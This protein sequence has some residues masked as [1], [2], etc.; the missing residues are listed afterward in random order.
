[1]RK[2]DKKI[3]EIDK[4]ICKNIEKSAEDRGNLSQNIL[5]QLRNF[6]EHIMI[7]YYCESNGIDISGVS[8]DKYN[9]IKQAI[10]YSHKNE[11]MNMLIN[12]HNLLQE[13]VSHYTL[14]EE[15]SERL[16]LKYYE[17]LLKTKNML[18]RDFGLE[19]LHN[20]ERFPINLDDRQLKEYYEKITDKLKKNYDTKISGDRYYIN[21]KKPLFINNEIYYEITFS[22]ANDKASKF[23]RNI[24]FTKQDILTNYAVKLAIT[25]ETINMYGKDIPVLIIND[26]EVSIRPCELNNFA[27]ILGFNTGTQANHIE[28]KKLMDFIKKSGL[29]VLNILLL[30][31]KDY[32]EIR[33]RIISSSKKINIFDALDKC[34]NIIIN[35]Y[36][37]S[38]VLRYFIYNLNNKIIKLQRD[39]FGRKCEKLSDLKLKYGCIP[40]DEM[41]FASSL[42]HHNPK[43]YDL[44]SCIEIEDR[45]YELLARKIKN[46]SQ[47][48]GTLY[49]H[50]R[51]LKFLGDIN[52]LKEQYNSRLFYKHK[53]MRD[54]ENIGDNYY[55]YGY[56]E[57]VIN[58]LKQLKEKSKIGLKNYRNRID[59]WLDHGTYVID[60]YDKREILKKMF[61][62]SEVALVYG[63]AGTG[64][65]TMINH[66]SNFF[67]TQKKIFIA[68]TNPAVDNLKRRV[69]APNSEFMTIA[70]FLYSAKDDEYDLLVIDECSTVSN[71]DMNKILEK[72][73]FRLL[74]LVGDTYQ[75]K[76]ITFGNWFKIAK[77]YIPQKCVFE[78]TEPYR[79]K[80]RSLLNLWDRVRKNSNDIIEYLADNDYSG[81]LN[82]SIFSSEYLDEIILCLNYD[83]LYGINNVNRFFQSNNLNESVKWGVATYK[84]NDPVLFNETTRFSPVLFNNLKGKIIRI[85]KSEGEITFDVEV[86]R[87]ISENDITNIDLDLISSKRNSSIVRFSVYRYQNMS[88]ND[89]DSN[90]T[91]VPFQIAYAISIHKAQ[92]LE[93]DSVKVIITDEVGEL[94]THNILY[95]AITRAKSN[96]KIYWSPETEKKVIEGLKIDEGK[97]DN[98]I[99]KGK[100]R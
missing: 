43:I 33:E 70:K 81:S 84:V 52:A 9:E 89:N 21:K 95:T 58:I 74:L 12:F 72:A 79:T 39:K 36:P 8:E 18:S 15:N 91:I 24:A 54:I 3:L 41:P 57:K 88:D 1:M 23:D 7:K 46:N 45:R 67:K 14:N 10:S 50:K 38:N 30:E 94:I 51:E 53:P 65:S 5:A 73:N 35:N 4:N 83:G 32:T 13:S 6:V 11:E 62:G 49:T 86:D 77:S 26:W 71:Q 25:Q 69:L 99:L 85:K 98:S 76:S 80:N 66:I 100:L 61:S 27:D 34:R 55:I 82:N 97:R 47:N 37:G 78:L 20:I 60:C 87:V 92:G 90:D 29:S 19:I 42:V 75:I 28:Y 31:Q 59:N 96:L 93:F 63:A 48:N 44:F 64:K 22:E 56:E 16:M 68:N 17:Y 40:F 2:I